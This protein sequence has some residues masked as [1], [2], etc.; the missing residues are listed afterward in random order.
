MQTKIYVKISDLSRKNVELEIQIK[1]KV[2][3]KY[4]KKY[5]KVYI[6]NLYDLANNFINKNYPD[7]MN[8]DES[9]YPRDGEFGGSIYTEYDGT[10]NYFP[11]LF[12]KN[13]KPLFKKEILEI[14]NR[15]KSLNKQ[16]EKYNL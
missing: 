13:Y 10:K 14:E 7:K 4:I 3:N 2:N 16:L 11:D 12:E 8:N 1:N 9:R 15:L 6:N 5:K